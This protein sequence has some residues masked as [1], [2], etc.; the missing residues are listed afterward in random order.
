M[1]GIQETRGGARQKVIV[2]TPSLF[3]CAAR[4]SHRWRSVRLEDSLTATKLRP[5]SAQRSTEA[6]VDLLSHSDCA[7]GLSSRQFNGRTIDV[8]GLFQLLL[9]IQVKSDSQDP[10]VHGPFR[11]FN[12]QT[13]QHPSILP[14]AAQPIE[15]RPGGVILGDAGPRCGY[16]P[17]R[18]LLQRPRRS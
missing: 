2:N 18:R 8:A 9:L 7:S 3:I 11:I 15:T 4:H 13:S 1:S 10:T 5:S 14:V 16:L 17:F 12:G 6:A